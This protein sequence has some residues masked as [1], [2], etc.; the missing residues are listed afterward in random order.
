MRL[1]PSHEA[2][3]P[4]H[5]ML[6]QGCRRL[7]EDDHARIGEER[8]RDLDH[9][10]LGDRRFLHAALHVDVDA[11]ALEPFSGL[12]IHALPIDEAE[13]HRQRA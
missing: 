9:L 1:E 2:E 11:E 4:R 8:A 5:V 6:W 10:P 3:Q 13:A 7:V 12:A